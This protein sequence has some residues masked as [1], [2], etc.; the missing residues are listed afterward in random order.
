MLS[1][2]RSACRG[3]AA[4]HGEG[5]SGPRGTGR[6]PTRA[7]FTISGTGFRPSEII[8]LHWNGAAVAAL[9]AS[10]TGAFVVRATLGST[11]AAGV[12]SVVARGS[13]GDQAR[14]TFTVLA[15]APPAA[16][17]A[18]ATQPAQPAQPGTSATATPAAVQ[19]TQP[20]Q[21]TATAAP[22]QP[23]ATPAPG[24]PS[25]GPT[26][27]GCAI[28]TDQAQAE[29][30]L[31]TLLNAHRAVADVPPLALNSTLSAVSREHSRDMDQYQQL[32]HYGSDGSSP[33]DRMRAASV[34]F[35]TAGENIGMAGGYGLA[36]GVATVD[37]GMMAEPLTA[38]WTCSRTGVLPHIT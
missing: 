8:G 3:R 13:A 17:P 23:T 30:S 32:S 4:S 31:L 7:S 12:R 26:S 37:S 27:N 2:D 6:R 34:P 10:P 14:A 19:P 22:A 38:G 25:G 1:S 9:L 16:A 11:M 36:G 21:P 28:T 29:Q 18:T 33:F 5:S 20:T 24:I 35:A 15:L